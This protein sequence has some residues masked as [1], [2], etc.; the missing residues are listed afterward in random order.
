MADELTPQPG[1]HTVTKI[2]RTRRERL[3]VSLDGEYWL[4]LDPA[5]AESFGLAEGIALTDEL[6]EAISSA[7][8][9]RDAMLRAFRLLAHRSRSVAEIRIR[10]AHAGYELQTID[11]VVASLTAMGYLNDENFARAWIE[12]RLQ[13]GGFGRRRIYHELLAKG[14]DRELAQRVIDELVPPDEI[15]AAREAAGRRIASYQGLPPETARRRLASYL[16]RRGFAVETVRRI[17]RQLI[18]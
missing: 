17:C 8:A 2:A 9:N 14:I 18:D 16:T 13:V 11:H 3:S 5:V 1:S 6:C 15:D 10:L 4:N 7:A 12:Q